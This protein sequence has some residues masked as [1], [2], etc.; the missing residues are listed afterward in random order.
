MDEMKVD[1]IVKWPPPETTTQLRSFL[2][3]CN[4][5]YQFINHYLDKC[6]P[7][8]VLLQKM[9]PWDWTPVQH[10]AFEILKAAFCSKPV[11][12]MPDFLKPFEMECNTSLFATGGVLLQQDTNGDWHPVAYHSKSLSATEHNYQVYDCE[13]YAIIRC[14]R[15]WRCYIYSSPHD[16]TVWTDHHNLTYYTHPQKLT[17]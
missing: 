14:L 11:L 16:T 2:G 7:L 8:N 6:Q 10:S 12:L 15:D 3:F 17:R 13:L 9:R 1:G 5:Y 4:Y